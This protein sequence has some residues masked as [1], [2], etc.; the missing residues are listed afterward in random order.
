MVHVTESDI[1]SARIWS[2]VSVGKETSLSEPS[3]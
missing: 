3:V 2:F 1:S